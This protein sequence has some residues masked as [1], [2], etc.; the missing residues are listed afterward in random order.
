MPSLFTNRCLP[1]ARKRFFDKRRQTEGAAYLGAMMIRLGEIEGV[2]AACAYDCRPYVSPW[3]PINDTYGNKEKPFYLYQTYGRLYRAADA[4]LCQCEQTAGMKHTGIYAI[5]ASGDREAYCLIVS[6]DGCSVVD[7]RLDG[8]PDDLYSAEVYMLD[9]V[10][11]MS[12]ADTVALSGMKKRLL[13]NVS[14]YG[15]VLVRLY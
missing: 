7:L 4:A 6:F 13:L 11:N 8:I 10:K 9:G 2:G 5:A 1:E 15:A 12:L 14:N 3:C